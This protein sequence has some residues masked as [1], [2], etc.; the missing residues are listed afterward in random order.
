MSDKQDPTPTTVAETA[1]LKGLARLE[2]LSK[3]QVTGK[4]AGN[5]EP[6]GSW[7]YGEEPD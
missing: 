7:A 2:K 4:L 6:K 5:N 3:A 1:L